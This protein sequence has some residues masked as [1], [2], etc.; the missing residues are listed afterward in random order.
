MRY[1]SLL[2]MWVGL[3]PAAISAQA[4]SPA[5]S[6]HNAQEGAVWYTVTSAGVL[7][8]KAGPYVL[9]GCIS[10]SPIAPQAFAADGTYCIIAGFWSPEFNARISNDREE[11]VVSSTKPEAFKLYRN[12]PNPFR[13]STRIAYDLPARSNV[14]LSV[15]DA[16]GRRVRELAGGLQQAGHY[17]LSW[18][19]KDKSGRTCPCG[20]YFCSLKAEHQEV[21][22]K[23]LIAE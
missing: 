10:Q 2:S 3:L 22:R 17:S 21:V 13:L 14:S 8:D 20:V 19:G 18:D 11:V 5:V 9:S 23:M 15:Y 7:R 1:L 16:G 4:A 12:Y 6:E